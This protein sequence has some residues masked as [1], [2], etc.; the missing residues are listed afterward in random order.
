MWISLSDGVFFFGSGGVTVMKNIDLRDKPS[1]FLYRTEL[2]QGSVKVG[3]VTETS[4]EIQ[5]LLSKGKKKTND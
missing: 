4:E 2:L 3:F 1:T 5:K